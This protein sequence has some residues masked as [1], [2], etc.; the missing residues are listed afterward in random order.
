MEPITPFYA[1]KVANVVLAANG[2]ERIVTP[3][4]MYS[5]AK[6]HRIQTVEVPGNKKV[7]FDGDAFKAWLDGY[8]AGTGTVGKKDVEKLAAQYMK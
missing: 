7:H 4:M 1:A 5:Y 2:Q 3:Q 8:V 6:N